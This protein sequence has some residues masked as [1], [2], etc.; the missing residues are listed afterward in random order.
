MKSKRSTLLVDGNHFMFKSLYVIPRSSPDDKL[1]SREA[2]RIAYVKKMALDFAAEIRKFYNVIDRVVFTVDSSSWRKDYYP[3]KEYK[4]NRVKDSTV[5]W[6]M[7][8]MVMSEFKEILKSK[9]V[10]VHQVPGAEGDDIVYAWS[11]FLNLKGESVII[12]SGDQDLIQLVGYN[13]STDAYTIA[14]TNTNKKL[15]VDKKFNE[16]LNSVESDEVTSIFDTKKLVLGSSLAR[17]TFK[18]LISAN[19]LSLIVVD[20][21]EFIFKKVLTGD[22]G[23]NIASVY[24]HEKNGKTFGI[25]D[26]KAERILSIFE[27]KYGKFKSIYYFDKSYRQDIVKIIKENIGADGMTSEQILDNLETNVMLIMLHAKAIPDEI[28]KVLYNDTERMFMI[29]RP[30]TRVLSRRENILEGTQYND[31][32]YTPRT[33]DFFKG[34]SNTDMS[35]IKKTETK[36][37][38]SLF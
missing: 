19:N 29:K 23:D 16:W 1:L 22:R 32:T 24:F 6:D 18:E 26:K 25:S 30:D 3:Q 27:N 31:S 7:F 17:E 8:H 38:K 15:V 2:D 28:Q 34:D 20:A 35:F 36:D 12:V 33:F 37:N 10:I 9:G 11:S 5:D 13:D 4:A 14:Y 21:D